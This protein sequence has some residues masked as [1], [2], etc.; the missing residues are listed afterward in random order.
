MSFPRG[1]LIAQNVKNEGG[2]S[3]RN[4]LPLNSENKSAQSRVQ[5]SPNSN[6]FLPQISKRG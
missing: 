5:K 4:I 1:G 2:K 3:S 6:N